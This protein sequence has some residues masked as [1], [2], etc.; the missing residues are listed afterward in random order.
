L[1]LIEEVGICLWFGVGG[2]VKSGQ[3]VV[4]VVVVGV[5]QRVDKDLIQ[6]PRPSVEPQQREATRSG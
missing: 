1:N 5:E 4:V 3:V 6:N 2:G